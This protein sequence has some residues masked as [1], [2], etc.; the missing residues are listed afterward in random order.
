MDLTSAFSEINWLSVILST[1]AAFV[2]GSLWYSPVLFGRVW[3]R[4]INLSDEEIKRA[5]MA[6]IFGVS[7][8]F[9]FI[10]ALTLEMFIGKEADAAFGFTA[11]FLVGFAWVATSIGT[12]YLFARKSFRLFLI[13]AGYFLVFFSVMGLILGIM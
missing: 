10:A 13:D 5:N 7:F 6:V 2:L 3:Q 8:V 4:E 9:S 1:L 12:N 11:G